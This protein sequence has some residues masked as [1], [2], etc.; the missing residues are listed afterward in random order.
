VILVILNDPPYGS[1]RSYSGLRLAHALAKR[2]EPVRLFLMGDAVVC[3]ASGQRTPE[4]HYNTG[5]MVQAIG[6]RGAG[7]ACCGTCLDAR[8]LGEERLVEG[9]RRSTLDELAEWTTLADR[10]LVF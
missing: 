8:G 1:E 5:R 6:R 7:V 4:G 3:A 2:G 9:A 10:V